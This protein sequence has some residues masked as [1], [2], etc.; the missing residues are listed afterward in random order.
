M[1]SPAVRNLAVIGAGTPGCTT[2]ALLPSDGGGGGSHAGQMGTGIAL[3]ATHCA[4]VR[5]SN[6]LAVSHAGDGCNSWPYR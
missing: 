5:W 6:W 3:V 2:R 4:K 1:V